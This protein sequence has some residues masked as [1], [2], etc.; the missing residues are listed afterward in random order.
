MGEH[1]PRAIPRCYFQGFVY[2][3]AA[4]IVGFLI[5]AAVAHPIES[6][7][8]EPRADTFQLSAAPSAIHL[9][10]R[11]RSAAG[12]APVGGMRE[13]HGGMSVSLRYKRL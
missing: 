7:G 10:M 3:A 6:A 1:E 9:R 13:P 5:M 11:S 12:N 8:T 2:F 4:P